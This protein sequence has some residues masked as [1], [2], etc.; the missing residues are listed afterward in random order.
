MNC[1][2][3]AAFSSRHARRNSAHAPGPGA[4]GHPPIPAGL[5]HEDVTLLRL[6][7]AKEPS[8]RMLSASVVVKH[9]SI[10]ILVGEFANRDEPRR[11]KPA[12]IPVKPRETP[13]DRGG[14]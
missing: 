4:A 2:P 10:N 5:E 7:L 6:M 14:L 8:E 11:R 3:A 9:S 1:S 13:C 12:P